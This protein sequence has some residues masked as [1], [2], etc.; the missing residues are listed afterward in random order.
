MKKEVILSICGRQAYQDQE[1]DVIELVTEG[2]LEYRDGGWDIQYEES[3]LTGLSGVTTTFRVEPD[4][5]VLSRTGKLRSEM[6]FREGQSHNSLYQMEFGALMITVC[7]T[8]IFVQLDDN[9]GVID[10]VYS[11][12]IEQ[13]T[14]GTVDYHLVITPK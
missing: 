4:R 11:I 6:V 2:T 10:L 9:G 5:V 14:A 8:R 1:P 3:D 13:S 7:A 12:D